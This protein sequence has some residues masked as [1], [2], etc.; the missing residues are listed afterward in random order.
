[1]QLTECE[2]PLL[3][4]KAELIFRDN[5]PQWKVDLDDGDGDADD[6]GES[7]VMITMMMV[8]IMKAKVLTN[9]V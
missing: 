5:I 3:Q 8:M 4:Q 6:D 1:M 9:F 2:D 7:L